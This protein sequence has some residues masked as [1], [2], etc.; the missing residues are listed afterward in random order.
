MVINI[1]KNKN[2]KSEILV[3]NKVTTVETKV[4]N[5]FNKCFV[6]VG[7]T[8]AKAVA[9]PNVQYI[10]RNMHTVFALLCFVVVMHWLFFP[11]PSALLHLQSNPDEYG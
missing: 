8:L 11:Y 5:D 1:S 4:A 2:T 10:P 6:N 9:R 3:H 7:A